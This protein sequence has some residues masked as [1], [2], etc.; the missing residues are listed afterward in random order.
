[1]NQKK[2]DKNRKYWDVF[3]FFVFVL[4]GGGEM[5]RIGEKA[6]LPSVMLRR[7]CRAESRGFRRGCS[8]QRN[9]VKPSVWPDFLDFLSKTDFIRKKHM[10]FD[11]KYIL[12]SAI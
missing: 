6:S 1:M 5:A 10:F 3:V 9:A 11:K 7:R 2:L 12:F 4:F 8:R